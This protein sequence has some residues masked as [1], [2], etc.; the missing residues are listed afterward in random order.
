MKSC[1]SIKI[2]LHHIKTHRN[3]QSCADCFLSEKKKTMSALVHLST[4]LADRLTA[5]DQSLT[6]RLWISSCGCV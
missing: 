5:V 2:L 3:V 6:P 1:F 4:F